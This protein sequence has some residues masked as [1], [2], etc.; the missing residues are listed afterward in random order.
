MNRAHAAPMST[1]RLA[2]PACILAVIACAGCG[3][4]PQASAAPPAPSPVAA[5]EAA[6]APVAAP[7]APAAPP[8]M[9][10][11]VDERFALDEA[12]WRV[13]FHL[14]LPALPEPAA[15][16]VRRACEAW[17]FQGLVAP[18]GDFAE[19]AREAHRLLV[20]D[21]PHAGTDPW[22][23]ERAVLATRLGGGWLALSRSDGSFAGGERAN[24]KLEGLVVEVDGVRALELDEIVPAERQPDLRRLLAQELRRQRQLPASGPITSV[25]AS[26]DELPIPLPI[27]GDAG[28]RFVWNAYEI[29]PAADGAFAVELPAAQLKPLFARDPW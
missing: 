10:P 9:A 3:G 28:A 13:S 22:Y 19:S 29:A 26:D 4:R 6:T 15:R 25:V 12:G 7:S 11:A 17:L 20:S 27:I 24:A 1:P 8:V 2:A 21:T 23:A 5:A 18:R 14:A 16:K